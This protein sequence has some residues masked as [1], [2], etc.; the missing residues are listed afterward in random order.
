[1]THLGTGTLV[2]ALR[3][4]PDPI[5][6]VLNKYTLCNENSSIRLTKFGFDGFI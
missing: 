6:S 4:I 3:K 5:C 1:M 2:F